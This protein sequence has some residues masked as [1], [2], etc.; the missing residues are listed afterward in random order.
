MMLEGRVALIT[1]AGSGIGK[2]IAELF[3]REGAAVCLADR[4]LPAAE[5]AA[6]GIRGGG[7]GRA[8]AFLMDVTAEAQVE[9]VVGE[10]ARRHPGLDILVNSAGILRLAPF[11]E[12]TTAAW[13]EVFAVNV[14]GAF[15]TARAVARVMARRGGGR[16]IN[17]G[18]DSGVGSFPQEAAYGASKAALIAMTRAMARDL[19]PL[20]IRCNAVCPGVTRSPFLAGTDMQDPVKE[21]QL[22][23]TTA[24]GRIGEPEDAARVALFFASSLSDYVT[25]EHLLATGG[26]VM[27]Q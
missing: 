6:A 7:G 18:S 21:R 22:A 11:L 10:V 16:I 23:A 19:G 15:L 4:D 1:G 2:A 26:G 25:G 27:S 17:I 14:R 20:G 12:L 8:E 9:G 5:S 13:D 3:A 24:L